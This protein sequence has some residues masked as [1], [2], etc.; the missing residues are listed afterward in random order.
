MPVTRRMAL[1]SLA[2]LLLPEHGFAFGSDG[3]FHARVLTTGGRKLDSTRASGPGRWAWELMRRTSAP[4]RLTSSTVRAAGSELLSEPFAIWAGSSDVG[5]LSNAELKGLRQFLMLGG[6]LVVDDSSPAVGGFSRSVKRELGRVI[7]ESP[8]V[9]LDP[10][11]VIYKTYYILDRPVGRVMGPPH[12]EAIVRGKNAQVLFLAHD[13]LGAL[14]RDT[15]D[16]WALEV[17]PGSTRQRQQAIRLAVNIGMYVLCSDYKDDQVHAP[18]LMRRR[19][20]RSHRP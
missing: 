7:P 12:M 11:H 17:E 6:L 13:L 19:A 18:W 3:A 10:T 5:E 4:A 8:V 1:A 2:T 15:S 20:G 16:G 9:K 14:A